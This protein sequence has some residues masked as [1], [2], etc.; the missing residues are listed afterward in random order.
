MTDSSRTTNAEV[1]HLIFVGSRKKMSVE[2]FLNAFYEE[3]NFFLISAFLFHFNERGS[4]F[5]NNNI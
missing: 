5:V 3:I 2:A 1:T 4:K